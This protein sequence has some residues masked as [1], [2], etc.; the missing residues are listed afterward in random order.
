M[1]PT[2]QPL[3]DNCNYIDQLQKLNVGLR[4][5][6]RN[7]LY[8]QGRSQGGVRGVQNKKITGE[9]KREQLFITDE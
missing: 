3:H 2:H 1:V 6:L 7:S 5:C 8:L 9:T 4:Q